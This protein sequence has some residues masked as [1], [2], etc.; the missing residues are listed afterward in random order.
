[1]DKYVTGLS[2][3]VMN[4]VFRNYKLGVKKTGGGEVGVGRFL[5]GS[6]KALGIHWWTMKSYRKLIA[7]YAF[8]LLFLNFN[9]FNNFI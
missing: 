1:M 9:F 7:K 8:M 6:L 4:T 2:P 3:Q 5:L